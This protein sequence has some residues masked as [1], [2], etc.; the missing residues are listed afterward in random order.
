MYIIFSLVRFYSFSFTFIFV[1][2]DFDILFTDIL[3]YQIL[4]LSCSLYCYNLQNF[5][6]LCVSDEES[7]LRGNPNPLLENLVVESPLLQK[8]SFKSVPKNCHSTN[9]RAKKIVYLFFFILLYLFVI[10][11]FEI[12]VKKNDWRWKWPTIVQ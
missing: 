9:L 3:Y 10:S 11:A 5:R 8:I 2:G 7:L 1:V 12:W 4:F 6:F